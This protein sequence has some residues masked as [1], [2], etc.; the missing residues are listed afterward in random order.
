MSVS[1]KPVTVG[2]VSLISMSRVWRWTKLPLGLALLGVMYWNYRDQLHD[3]VARPK[4]WGSLAL[5]FSMISFSTVLV[6]VRWYL[7]VWAL[8]IPF[9]LRDAFRLGF[10][11]LCLVFAG[12]GLVGADLFK[13]YFIAREQRQH[14]AQAAATVL[15]D[16]ILGLIPLV[17]LGAFASLFAKSVASTMVD[18]GMRWILWGGS[19]GGI[20]GLVVMLQPSFTRSIWIRS[21]SKLPYVGRI[22]VEVLNGVTLYQSRPRVLIFAV[23]MGFVGHIVTIGGF[24]YGALGVR[25]DWA[26]D[27]I[28]H[29]YFM[30]L[31]EVLG[32]LPSPVPGGIGPLELAVGQAYVLAA[33]DAVPVEVARSAG[34]DATIAFRIVNF[35]LAAVGGVYYFSARK[36]VQAA[37][38]EAK[39]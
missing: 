16:R 18:T 21:L 27:L 30:P 11:G 25:V 8:D 13:A 14:K 29:L 37:L 19:V 35:L 7:L 10:L 32:M 5:A 33:G 12:P 17:L 3:F 9:R 20:L 31:A 4:D 28:A 2:D 34:I 39:A 36:E 26:P 15:L 22:F 6:I 23:L 1:L 24:Y 38:A